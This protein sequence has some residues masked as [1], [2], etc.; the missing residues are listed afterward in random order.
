MEK[1]NIII[2]TNDANE[3]K[4]CYLLASLGINDK[5]YIIY[6]DVDNKDIDK[7]LMASRIEML[8]QEMQLFPLSEEEWELVSEEYS[9]IIKKV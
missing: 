5:K 6:K 3:K 1:D 8:S 4:E 9:K 2:V 7:N